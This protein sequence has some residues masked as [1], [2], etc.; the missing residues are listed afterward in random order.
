MKTVRYARPRPN[1]SRTFRVKDMDRLGIPHLGQPISFNMGNQ[2]QV[3]MSNKMSES[4]VAKLPGEFILFDIKGN[5]EAPE[6]LEPLTS[7]TPS[8]SSNPQ[9]SLFD[10]EGDPDDDDESSTGDDDPEA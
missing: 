7:L 9:E 1:F 3:V 8:A 5:D 6:V 2:F 4:F 10:S